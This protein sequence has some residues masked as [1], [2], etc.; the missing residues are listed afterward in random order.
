M[1]LMPSNKKQKH[2]EKCV[3]EFLLIQ[4]TILPPVTF[5]H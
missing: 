3:S 5:N 2:N 4:K 1:K